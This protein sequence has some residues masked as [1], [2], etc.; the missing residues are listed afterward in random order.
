[1][2]CKAE[3]AKKTGFSYNLALHLTWAAILVS[4]HDVAAGGPGK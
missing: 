2:N 1:M 3:M 4:R